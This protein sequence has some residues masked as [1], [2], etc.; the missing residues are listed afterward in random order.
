M[1]FR[2]ILTISFFGYGFAINYIGHDGKNEGNL[3]EYDLFGGWGKNLNPY[4]TFVINYRWITFS[5][6]LNR[7]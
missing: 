5:L 1:H 7:G 4:I 3:D 6:L 2:N